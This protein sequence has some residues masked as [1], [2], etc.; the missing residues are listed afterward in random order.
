MRALSRILG[1]LLIVAGI[2]ALGVGHF[3]YTKATH[4]I[5]VGPI[6]L[7]VKEQQDVVL[8]VWASVAAIAVGAVLMVLGGRRR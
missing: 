1:A 4:E 7:A 2:L 3:S 5:K 8:P 6:A